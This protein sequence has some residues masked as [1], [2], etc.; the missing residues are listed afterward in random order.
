MVQSLQNS[1]IVRVLLVPVFAFWLT[2]TGCL[3]G[4]QNADA[5]GERMQS[6]VTAPEA[7]ATPQGHDCCTKKQKSA[8]VSRRQVPSILSPATLA[9]RF[10]SDR[11]RVCPLAINATAEITKAN[12]TD[13]ALT[14]DQTSD[15]TLAVREQLAS[16]RPPT[17]P[18]NREGTYLRC[19]TFL[20]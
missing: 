12:G 11:L 17:P 19:C 20:I 5:A 4:C 2:G 13:I 6:T 3:L 15:H 9:L 8:H 7:C 10:S 18:N 1:K 14:A 16:F